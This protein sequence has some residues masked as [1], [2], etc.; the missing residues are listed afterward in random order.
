MSYCSIIIVTFNGWDIARECFD[1]LQPELRPGVE[2]TVVDNGSTDGLPRHVRSRYAGVNL[3]EAGKNLGFAAGNN[4]GIQN[5]EGDLVILLNSD[6]IVRPGFVDQLLAPFGDS[7]T[8]GSVSAGLVFQ[9]RPDIVASAGIEVFE[10]G[11]ALDRSLGEQVGALED[12]QPI[13]GASAGAAA[14][15]RLALNDVGLFPEAFFMYL[16]DVDLAWRLRLRGWESVLATGAVAEH[17]YS[18]SSGEGSCFKRRLLARN[19]IWCMA[20][21]LPRWMFAR[22]GWKIGGYDLL[23]A[24][25]AIARKDGASFS[26]RAEALAGLRPRLQERWLI[27]ARATATR[28]DIESWLMPSPSGKRLR[29]LREMTRS[30]ASA[31]S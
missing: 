2:L 20:R 12:Q 5:T 30:Y 17:A 3:I 10:N 4:L 31:K 7:R 25:S 13:F 11:L 23:V 15:R 18:S 8:V 14:F 28:A 6:V 21:C 19:R 16:E 24:A 27:Q 26:G 22:H 29:R 1:A 9:T